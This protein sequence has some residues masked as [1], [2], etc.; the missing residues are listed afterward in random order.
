[1]IDAE[2]EIWEQTEL[3]TSKIL[4]LQRE[5]IELR[6]REQRLRVERLE[7][8]RQLRVTEAEDQISWGS[9]PPLRHRYQ[10]LRLL[11]RKRGVEVYKAHDLVVLQ[12]CLLRLYRLGSESQVASR[13]KMLEAADQECEALRQLNHSATAA[14]LDYFRV[15]GGSSYATVWEFCRGETLETYM[16]R[17]RQLPERDARGILLQILGILRFMD[18]KGHKLHSQDLKRGRLILCG[19]EVRVSGLTVA[20]FERARSLEKNTSSQVMGDPE[21]QETDDFAAIG[22]GTDGAIVEMVAMIF[23]EM[24]F[25]KGP[26]QQEPGN[27]HLPEQPK[28]SA[29]CREYL[30]RLLDRDRRPT[31]Q[32]AWFDPFIAP[33]RRQ[34]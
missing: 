19:G 11:G 14:L 13:E 17:N 20:S 29:E 22:G 32:E 16:M 24:L 23:H 7:Y 12:P 9:F 18:A 3:R 34:R 5:D 33:A 2:E 30:I 25:G 1:M 31:I 10:L 15:E 8:L 4:A 27:V 28:V 21:T 26:D 6:D